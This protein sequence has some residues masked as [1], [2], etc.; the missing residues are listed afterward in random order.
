M[1]LLTIP[2]GVILS[3]EPCSSFLS[4]N[5]LT[6]PLE[7]DQPYLKSILIPPSSREERVLQWFAVNLLTHGLRSFSMTQT[8]VIADVGAKDV[9]FTFAV[10]SSQ[11]APV[12]SEVSG[13]SID[14]EALG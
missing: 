1:T 2:K 14:K 4:D 13:K 7:T 3:G 9:D 5:G 10:S 12:G 6:I 11:K 8:A